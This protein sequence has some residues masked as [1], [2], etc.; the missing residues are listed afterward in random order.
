MTANSLIH[1]H[2]GQFGVLAIAT[3][4]HIIQ[5]Q[6]KLELK[7]QVVKLKMSTKAG[8]QGRTT[9]SVHLVKAGETSESAQPDLEPCSFR[10]RLI[11]PLDFYVLICGN[12]KKGKSHKCPSRGL[13]PQPSQ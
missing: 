10:T 7:E 11:Q 3:V 2:G 5:E 1:T 13:S 9:C 6:E 12:L 4:L 8:Y